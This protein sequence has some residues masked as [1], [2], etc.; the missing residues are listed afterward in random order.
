MNHLRA[1][2]AMYKPTTTVSISILRKGQTQDVSVTL[3]ERSPQ[4]LRPVKGF[5]EQAELV[6]KGLSV[7][8]LTADLAEKLGHT[9]D[10][11]VLIATGA[12]LC[13]AG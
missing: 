12:D 11:G 8:N 4:V 3:G 2:V 7:Q 5:E 13:C 10:E 1:T 9:S 6:W